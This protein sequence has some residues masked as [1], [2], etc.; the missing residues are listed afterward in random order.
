MTCRM[1]LTD[2]H[3]P[4]LRP[5]AWGRLGVTPM[6]ISLN[7]HIDKLTQGDNVR[8]AELALQIIPK[9]GLWRPLSSFR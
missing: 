2:P 8:V 5:G 4:F 3:H 6:V 1:V 9:I 7:V